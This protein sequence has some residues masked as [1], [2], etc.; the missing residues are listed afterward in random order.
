MIRGVVLCGGESKRMGRDKGLIS[1][2]I[3]N[4]AAL[5]FHKLQQLNLPVCVSINP[6]QLLEYRSFFS[7]EQLI[8]DTTTAKGPLQGLLS[9][10]RK[11]PDD[12]L[13]LLACDMI[14]MDIKT[15]KELLEST[16]KFPGFDH[17]LYEQENFIEPLCALY[18]SA[19]LKTVYKELI[20]DKLPGYAMHKLI[21]RGNYKT[22]PILNARAL[23]NYNTETI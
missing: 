2:G 17:Y 13:L 7:S 15:L 10:H 20:S 1:L 19:S 18:T 4:W 14:D 12:D 9:V 23:N 3:A 5:A 22:F 16:T 21:N 11:Y 8:M 6:M